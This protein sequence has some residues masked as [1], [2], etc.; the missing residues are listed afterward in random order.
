LVFA[1]SQE[2]HADSGFE[3]REIDKLQRHPGNRQLPFGKR[4]LDLAD[5]S[6]I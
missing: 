2:I 1:Q 5:A 4:Q 3:Q 6:S